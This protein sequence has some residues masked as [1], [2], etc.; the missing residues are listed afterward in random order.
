[1][2]LT[3]AD[4]QAA[5][6]AASE[7]LAYLRSTGWRRLEDQE[8]LDLRVATLMVHDARGA[9]VQ[10]PLLPEAKDYPRRVAELVNIAAEVEGRSPHHLLAAIRVVQFDVVRVRRTGRDDDTLPVGDGAALFAL[11]NGVFVASSLAVVEP[12]ATYSGRRPAKVTEFMETVRLGQTEQGSFVVRLLVPLPSSVGQSQTRLSFVQE[13]VPPPPFPRQV[14]RQLIRSVQRAK[15]AVTAA[16]AEDSLDPFRGE[17]RNGVSAELCK[18]LNAI[19]DVNPLHGVEIGIAWGAAW[20]MERPHPVAFTSDALQILGQAAEF[21]AAKET[22]EDFWLEGYI[23]KLERDDPAGEIEG[24][25]TIATTLGGQ[26]R[27]VRVTLQPADYSAA[28]DAHRVGQRVRVKGDLGKE[29][30]R[31]RL[32]RPV[33]FSVVEHDDEEE[34]SV[35]A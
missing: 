8:R 17:V 11:A 10:V 33:Q 13:H 24:D 30:R 7:L 15:A 29:G 9:E 27:R 2:R 25:V 20:P 21:L 16:I 35:S 5:P 31:F 14:T 4:V 6:V 28:A 18:A 3:P 26:L 34:T 12:R 22:L 1:M 23:T 19:E 32:V